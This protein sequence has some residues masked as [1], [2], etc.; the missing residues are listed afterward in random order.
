VGKELERIA[1][2]VADANGALVHAPNFSV[3]VSLFLALAEAA[4]RAMSRAPQFDAHIV[5]THHAAKKDA[6]SGTAIA[7]SGPR[8]L[9]SGGR[10]P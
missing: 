1:R 9:V 6:P 7:S 10:F 2:T 3:G 4:G 5:E 8:Q